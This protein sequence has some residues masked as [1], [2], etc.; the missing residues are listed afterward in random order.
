MARR[1]RACGGGPVIG[2]FALLEKDVKHFARLR[3]E[4]QHAPGERWQA[5]FRIVEEAGREFHDEYVIAPYRAVFDV[6]LA[7]FFGE[8]QLAYRRNV[9]LS[10]G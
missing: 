4:H 3:R 8:Q 9:D 5:Q 2:E 6:K 10:L 7:M 1:H